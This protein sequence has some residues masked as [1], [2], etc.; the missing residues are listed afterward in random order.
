MVEAAETNP[1][2]V[3]I[4]AAMPAGTGLNLMQEK[5]PD[6]FFDV[7]ICEQHAVTFAAGLVAQGMRPVCALYSTF[8]QRGYDQFIHDVCLQNLPV[9]FAVDRAGFVGEDS[10]THNGA[11]DLSFLRAVPNA[12]VLA[13]RDDLDLRAMLKWAI[14][15]P[16]PVVIRYPRD[17]APTIGPAEPRDVT[18][19]EMLRDGTDAAFLAVGPCVGVCLA[20]SERLAAEGVSV[21]VADARSVKPVD[22]PLIRSLAGRPVVTVEEN[23][24]A[25]GFGSAVM[26]YLEREGLL[27]SARI[28]RIG[29]P[30]SFIDHA[31]RNQQLGSYGLDPAGLAEATKL[32]LG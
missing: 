14:V 5:F 8:L 19:G 25:G 2:L 12:V 30:D 13:P 9:V 20:A 4:T 24:L 6:R 22:G 29:F 31:T 15:Q 23:A 21:G 17:K 10:P 28:R 18:R 3:G 1:K 11:F 26:E 32:W 16:G 27:G 7:G